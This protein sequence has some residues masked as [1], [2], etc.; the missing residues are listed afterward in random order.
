MRIQFNTEAS[1]LEAWKYLMRTGGGF[2]YNKSEQWV[3]PTP[4]GNV[5]DAY[6]VKRLK[7]IQAC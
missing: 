4:E 7:E 6:T 2:T 1:Y 5:D 3:E